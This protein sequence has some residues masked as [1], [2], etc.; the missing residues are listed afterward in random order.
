ML[1]PTKTN[2]AL[3][4]TL[5]I[6][7]TSKTDVKDVSKRSSSGWLNILMTEIEKPSV[8]ETVYKA[9]KKTKSK[10]EKMCSAKTQDVENDSVTTV[11]QTTETDATNDKASVSTTK[12]DHM[13]QKKDKPFLKI[14]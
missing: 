14:K 6:A 1:S 3:E 10:Q 8:T 4:N 12:T 5:E 9:E 7:G 2:A 13:N 11:N